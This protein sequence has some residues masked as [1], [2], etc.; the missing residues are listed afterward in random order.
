MNRSRIEAQ[1]ATRLHLIRHAEVE[2]S[3][4][5]TFGGILDMD[6]SERGCHQAGA[7]ADYLDRA[8]LDAAY[9]SPMKRVRQTIDA[10]RSH[11]P[12]TISELDG[13]REVHFGAWTGLKWHE[14][15]QR[16]RQSA[17][18]WLDLLY[19]GG[20]PQAESAEDFQLRVKNCLGIIM[21]NHPG[22]AVAIV[23]HGGVIRMI[24]SLLLEWP[25][26]KMRA[27]DVEY[28]SVSQVDLCG[29][30][31]VIRLLNY[32]PWYNLA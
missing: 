2:E 24:L 18:D 22:Q 5:E 14:V 3:F 26:P 27:F 10:L 17:F 19:H 4:H 16:Y 21:A 29:G 11:L 1:S 30:R 12:D 28:A 13:L 8:A 31:A 20:I 15:Q 25:L 7:L 6:L 32:A 9:A 23:C